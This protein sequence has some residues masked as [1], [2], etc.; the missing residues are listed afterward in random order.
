MSGRV[1]FAVLVCLAT[2]VPGL[3]GSA[4]AQECSPEA[5]KELE[6]AAREAADKIAP[7]GSPGHEAALRRAL[8][9]A[10]DM[11]ERGDCDAANR[12]Q[13]EEFSD[14]NKGD[15]FHPPPLRALKIDSDP[16]YQKWLRSVPLRTSLDADYL[17]FSTKSIGGNKP[18]DER[19]FGEV[20]ALISGAGGTFC[21]GLLVSDRVVL[22]AAHC[23]C[24]DPKEVQ[25]G[26]DPSPADPPALLDTDKMYLR[27]S[28]TCRDKNTLKGNDFGLIALKA[29]L[30]H[31]ASLKF[32]RL[33]TE[34]VSN[35]LASGQS[36]YVAGFGSTAIE[37]RAG[38]KNYIQTPVISPYCSSSA[39]Q[40][41]YGCVKR[42]ELV[43]VDP[44]VYPPN[45]SIDP[46]HPG[47]CHGDSGGGAFRVVG[48]TLYLV[49]IVSRLIKDGK[50]GDGAIYT[51]LSSDLV[52]EIRAHAQQLAQP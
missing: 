22:T 41:K 34:T 46:L 50:C 3:V 4:N 24:S 31:S 17:Q 32:V 6:R 7:P 27:A 12:F 1:L 8:G 38:Q 5:R 16:R 45:V 35:G 47:A 11:D 51:L 36:L 21:S 2:A 20:V 29:S 19:L 42:Q 25:M 37:G 14:R 39:D 43:S 9:A 13:V 23:L 18:S 15:R 30:G 10:G 49:G 33:A 44:R 26:I 28:A 52:A 48:N 40:A